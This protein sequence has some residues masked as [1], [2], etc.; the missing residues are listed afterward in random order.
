MRFAPM[1]LVGQILKASADMPSR[2]TPPTVCFKPAPSPA[3]RL[4]TVAVL[5]AAL[6]L[7]ACGGGGDVTVLTS[8]GIDIG[9]NVAGSNYGRASGGQL[10][11]VVATVGQTVA[12]DANEPVEWSFAVNGSPLFLN[13]TTVDVGGVTITQLQIDNS[14]VVL[15]SNFYGPALLPIDVVLVA[16]SRFDRAQVSTIEL[17]LR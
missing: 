17:S 4:L 3:G 14:R 15:R 8:P 12:F 9:V 16:T 2:A 11:R 13:G 6:L 5:G 7:S 1:T 10:F